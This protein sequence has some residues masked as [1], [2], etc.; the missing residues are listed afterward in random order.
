MLAEKELMNL[1]KAE[2]V[3]MA[4]EKGISPSGTKQELAK[5]IISHPLDSFEKTS[6]EDASAKEEEIDEDATEQ[7]ADSQE[8]Q[9]EQSDEEAS[10]EG[11][12]MQ[13]FNELPSRRLVVGGIHS[14][15]YLA[16]LTVVFLLMLGYGFQ[17]N[18]SNEFA[19]E[20]NDREMMNCYMTV[21]YNQGLGDTSDKPQWLEPYDPMGKKNTDCAEM[22]GV[23][24][25]WWQQQMDQ[26]IQDVLDSI[27]T[28]TNG[29]GYVWTQG[30]ID[31]MDYLGSTTFG[32]NMSVYGYP[33]DGDQFTEQHLAIWNGFTFALGGGNDS[34]EDL[35]PGGASPFAIYMP[36]GIVAP[37]PTGFIWTQVGIDTMA[38]LGSTT[39]GAN[40]SVFGDPVDGDTFTAQ[41][42]AVWNGFTSTFPGGGNDTFGNLLAG[43]A[44]PFAIYMP[45]GVLDYAPTG[46]LWSHPGVP[47]MAY[48]GSATFGANM[49]VYGDPLPGEVFSAQDL[50]VWNGFTLALGGG[51]DTYDH[52]L[53]GGAS[54]FAIYMP[55][56]IVITQA[57]WLN[58]TPS[59]T[60][61]SIVL[62]NTTTY[63]TY[64]CNYD[65]VDAQNG[66][67]NSTI[68]WFVNGSY[69]GNATNYTIVNTG[70]I[71]LMCIVT[72]YDSLYWGTVT[73]SAAIIVAASS[74]EEEN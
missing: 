48:L 20:G 29:T 54:P 52:L 27:T 15:P 66:T 49:S 63:S 28:S 31:T 37:Q 33:V 1:K 62:D 65:F 6:A 18:Y 69:A 12:K 57:E 73:E 56:G 36:V 2:L 74:E 60:N 51:N 30:G 55:A 25:N 34:I 21:Y 41:N 67:D 72:P 64:S 71:S 61:V 16:T 24:P 22:V 4:Q 5:R 3:E 8:T 58:Q 43:G 14:K 53:P 23:D 26:E 19:S 11:V 9:L 32:A 7:K 10:E 45:S 44:S 46:Y 59:V 13:I 47:T 38:Y 68:A 40:M 42:L 17:V 39:F 35:L 70:G 50:A